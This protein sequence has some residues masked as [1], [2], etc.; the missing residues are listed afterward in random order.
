M[1]Y[2]YTDEEWLALYEAEYEDIDDEILDEAD[3]KFGYW[4]LEEGT[5]EVEDKWYVYVIQRHYE[6]K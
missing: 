1:T 5:Y 2:T 6:T 4:E 3:E